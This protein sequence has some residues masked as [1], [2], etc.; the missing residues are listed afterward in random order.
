MN[1][2]YKLASTLVERARHHA[3]VASGPFKGAR[4]T[5][6]ATMH[7][8]NK[9]MGVY[10]F[11]LHDVLEDAIASNPP[12][13]IDVG[14]AEGYY[15]LGLAHRLP[16][17]RHLAYEM[18]DETRQKLDLSAASVNAAI[19]TRR[20]CTI[21]SLK[22]DVLGSDRGF[23]LM[24]CEGC[25]DSLL[26]QELLAPLAGWHVLLEVHDY[27]APGAG[28]K[29][30]QLFSASHEISVVYSREPS[31]SDLAPIAPWPLNVFCLD[32]FRKMFEEGR[33]CVMRFFYMRPKQ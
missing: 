22:A 29:I 17:A 32:S 2:T 20:E 5:L 4:T 27:H 19:E 12:L 8:W 1:P 14:A 23:L 28:E 7:D 21:E 15:T 25:E 3:I 18:L 11:Y 10:E 26:N 13:C 16:Q 33:G 30:F 24:D 31:A 9:L 6:S